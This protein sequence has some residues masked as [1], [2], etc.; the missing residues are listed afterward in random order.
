MPKNNIFL[1]L[2]ILLSFSACTSL[3][4]V[5]YRDG[6]L[7]SDFGYPVNKEIERSFYVLGDGG[8]SK[9]GGTSAG[10]LALEAFLDSVKQTGNYT[11]FLGDNIYPDGMEKEGHPLRERGEYR[12]DAQLEVVDEYDGNVLFMPGNHDWYNEGLD[13]LQRQRD[14]IVSQLGDENAF[15]PEPGCPLKSIDVSEKVQLLV[16]DSQWYLVDW[17]KNPLINKDCSIKTREALFL[18]LE[19]ELEL[20]QDKIVVFAIHHPLYTN[21]VH[22]GAY[23]FNSHIY[24]SQNK[25]P[26][27]ILGSI[28]MLAR[29]S[30]GVS[31]TD[32][33]NLRYK[34][35]INRLETVVRD[36]DNVV[37]VS[38]H[39]HSLQYIEKEGLKQIVSGSGSKATY[40]TLG[41]DGLFAY[42]GQGFV[43]LDVFEDGSVWASFYG[44]EDYQPKLLYQ[45][46]VLQAPEDLAGVGYPETFPNKVK[47]SVYKPSKDKRSEPFRSVWGKSYRDLYETPIEAEVASLDTLLG[48]LEVVR[49]GNEG[50]NRTL[51]L[52]DSLGRE[53]NL[54]PVKKDKVQFLRTTRNTDRWKGSEFR[55]NLNE[56][57]TEDFYT[58]SHPYVFLTIPELSEAAGVAYTN[59]KLYY[60]PKQ[61]ALQP[62]NEEFGDALYIIEERPEGDWAAYEPFGAPEEEIE[63]TLD[64]FE[65]RRRN[66]NFSIDESAYIRARI[67]DMLVGDW[68]SNQSKWRWAPFEDESGN[69][70]FRPIPRDR[71]QAF[72]NFDGAFMS[73]LRGMTGL[74]NQFSIYEENIDNLRWFNSAALGLD[75]TLLQNTTRE[76]WIE[77]AEYIQT[78]V[79][80]EAIENAFSHIPAA[81]QGE[82][83]EELKRILKER[84][85][86]LVDIIER[87]YKILAE[88]SIVT[89]TD[90]HDY[91]EVERLSD[92][93]TRVS[94]NRM[95][96]GEKADVISTKV[97]DPQFTKEIWL[98]GLNGND[99]LEVLGEEYAD[100]LVRL[101][102]GH[103][104]DIFRVQRGEKVKI[105]DYR[106]RPNIIDINNGADLELTDDYDINVFDKDRKIYS[107]TTTVPA[108]GY[109]PD[110][111]FTLGVDVD[112]TRYQFRR[113]PFTSQHG[114][115]AIYYSATDGYEVH[116]DGE[117]ANSWGDYNLALGA[118]FT[119]PKLSRNFFGYGNE[120]EYEED[121]VDMEYH[122]V[123]LSRIGVEAGF[124]KE[125]PFGTFLKYTASFE[126]VKVEPKENSF[127][128]EKISPVETFFE[129]KY[130]FGLDGIFRYASY[131][132]VL[133]PSNGM[134]FNFNV[135]GRMN[136]KQTDQVFGFLETYLGFYRALSRNRK[137]VLNPR[138][139]A[140]VNF[141]DDFEFYQAATLGGDTGLRGYR[142]YRFTGESALASGTDLRYSLERFETGV[143]P[144]QL[145]VFAGYDV[146]RVWLDGE[147][148]SVWHDSYGG[149]IWL[150]G[151]QVLTGKFNMFRGSE[152]WRFFFSMGLNF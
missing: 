24:P 13:G 53:Y 146:G 30:G 69:Q 103:D 131:D 125:S 138:V 149:G 122:R 88:Y 141:G 32:T 72:S 49:I 45:K 126:G 5:L 6:E 144:L 60:I 79:T 42:E 25:M 119:I 15:A 31:S 91:A 56:D 47:A 35:L 95:I 145:G 29:T 10:L 59:P 110:D 84:R 114:I 98:Y 2:L 112:F 38:G 99:I 142:N 94:M 11:I 120:T 26:V 111:G 115:S 3:N 102:G 108:L 96:N 44:S 1:T 82:S 68:D 50:E 87:Y 51:R 143:I 86:N 133:N 137:L 85:Q 127:L 19:N 34:T 139:E 74:V 73:T 100:I 81:A 77:Q 89:G 129:R 17:D 28:V 140:K 14:Y 101:I 124:V 117:F 83:S 8:Y 43:A 23:N 151:A 136:V 4:E 70:L 150:V 147:N 97:Y 64:V 33:Q 93:R 7:T 109:N 52:E 58:A 105:Y 57:V 9:P 22:G 130:F 106:S 55:E 113:N 39:E 75:R 40:V 123:G 12:I 107:T 104:E 41:T 152:G 61:K 121:A 78:N 16:V 132:N 46:E 135:G 66:E 36:H 63:T 37:F 71:D 148:S 65:R 134:R 67:F 76:E 128:A 116:Y 90:E 92:G 20:H 48:G 54:K 27:P 118:N 80:D 18:A 21:G 62:Y